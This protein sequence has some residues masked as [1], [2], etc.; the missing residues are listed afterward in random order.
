MEKEYNLLKGYQYIFIALH[1]SPYIFIA[2]Y[3]GAHIYFDFFGLC[4]LLPMVL[5]VIVG[6]ITNFRNELVY[7]YR[8]IIISEQGIEYA[9]P[10]LAFKV[11]T[12]PC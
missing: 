8:R 4:L 12:Q 1:L 2:I 10:Y 11:T 9:K 7:P 6:I 3:F 5:F